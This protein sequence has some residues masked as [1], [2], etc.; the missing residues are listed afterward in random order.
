MGAS[1]VKRAK[2]PSDV[3]VTQ[4]GAMGVA[5]YLE[6]YGGREDHEVAPRLRRH[7]VQALLRHH[8]QQDGVE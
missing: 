4:N 3:F 2:D 5:P 6:V 1:R 7:Q 8:L